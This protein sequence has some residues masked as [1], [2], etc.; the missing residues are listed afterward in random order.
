[1]N[2]SL[3]QF[4]RNIILAG[5]MATGKSAVGKELAR[6]LNRTL[7]DTDSL[8]EEM[9]GMTVAEIFA[10]QGEEYFRERESEAV[11][12]LD[13]YPAGSLVVST[14]GGILLRRENRHRLKQKGLLV[15]LS[16]SPQE[17]LR[18]ALKEGGRPLLE[19]SD[20]EGKIKELLTK[21]KNIYSGAAVEVDTTGRT[22]SEV[23]NEIVN[24]LERL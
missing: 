21:R 19:G 5:F 8:I 22:V 7:I 9:C 3:D 14:G 11:V 23:A 10:R 12:M 18:R 17:I 13:N 24:A 2:K 6:R 1:M 20:P 4:D 15:L 16:A